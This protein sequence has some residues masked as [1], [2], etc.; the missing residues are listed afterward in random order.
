M[1]HQTLR[2]RQPLSTPD[3]AA[4]QGLHPVVHRILAARGIDPRDGLDLTLKHLLPPGGFKDMGRAAERVAAAIRRQESIQIVGDYD[5][6][7]ATSTA[8][9]ILGLRSM[10]GQHIDYT[11]P[12]R[13]SDGYGLTSKLAGR[14][15]ASPPGLVITVDNGISSL[16]G[17]ELLQA[18]GVDVIVTDHH[19]AGEKLPPAYA[20][21]NPNQP[22]CGFADKSIAG[23]GVMFYLLLAVN[24]ALREQGFYEQRQRQPDL[25]EFLDLEIS[26]SHLITSLAWW[27]LILFLLFQ[28]L[29]PRGKVSLLPRIVDLITGRAEK[30]PRHVQ[31]FAEWKQNH[32]HGDQ[33]Q[34]NDQRQINR[35]L[36]NAETPEAGEKLLHHDDV[37]VE[38]QRH[39]QT[40]KAD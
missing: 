18:R 11:V 10:G 25:L 2:A 8:L 21:V 17:V 33:Q 22:G 20:I 15:A 1:L 35:Q 5:A 14:I 32:Q 38:H 19:L 3:A 23:V 28:R 29:R 26:L 31:Q 30:E 24:Q 39:H 12:N 27:R 36:P 4:G 6:D 34:V 13:F 7:G 37:G 9:A 40:A 16:Q